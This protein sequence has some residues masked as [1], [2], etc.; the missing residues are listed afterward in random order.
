[1]Y[2]KAFHRGS[3]LQ[4]PRSYLEA[5][6]MSTQFTD[7]YVKAMKK[8]NAMSRGFTRGRLTNGNV[9]KALTNVHYTCTIGD[10]FFTLGGVS[11]TAF[12]SI[13][14][15]LLV[16]RYGFLLPSLL[17][18]RYKSHCQVTAPACR[19]GCRDTGLRGYGAM[20]WMRLRRLLF[21]S[22]SGM[23]SQTQWRSKYVL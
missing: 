9:N 12:H 13:Q 10:T 5:V 3:R 1:M 19:A 22:V 7:P 21:C 2:T 11:K 6:E 4:A 8:K 18:A 15:S 20:Q 17:P 23:L 14:C 16:K